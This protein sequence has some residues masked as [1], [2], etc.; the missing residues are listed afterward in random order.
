VVIG[1]VSIW[2]IVDFPDDVNFLEPFEKYVVMSR[3]KNQRQTSYR[4]DKLK[5]RTFISVFKD[6]KLYV[7]FLTSMGIAG[8]IYA[9]SLFLPSIIKELGYS[10]T[11]AQLL[12][13]PQYAIAC[14]MVFVSLEV[15]TIERFS[16]LCGR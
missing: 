12:T 2:M 11:K 13:V 9:F 5:W 15:L 14:V 4:G 1:I 6:W 7:A 10:A 3:L 8:S 16:W